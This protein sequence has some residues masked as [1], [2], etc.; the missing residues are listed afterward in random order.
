MY[1]YDD[2]SFNINNKLSIF[3]EYR[4]DIGK[5]MLGDTISIQL[6]WINK[7]RERVEKAEIVGR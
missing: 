3:K 5:I 2:L 1:N 6:E 4:Y 7:E